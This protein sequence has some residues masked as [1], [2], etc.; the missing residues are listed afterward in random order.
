M[1]AR[2]AS[3]ITAET[4]VPCSAALALDACHNSSSTRTGR[5]GVFGWLG[6]RLTPQPGQLDPLRE[7]VHRRPRVVLVVATGMEPAPAGRLRRNGTVEQP[8]C[9]TDRVECHNAS[10]FSPHQRHTTPSVLL[11]KNS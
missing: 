3:R 8:F 4:V 5:R 11:V 9:A 6:T 2:S 7:L 1:N 10:F